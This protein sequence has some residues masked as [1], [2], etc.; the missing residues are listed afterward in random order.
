MNGQTFLLRNLRIITPQRTLE[1]ASLFI[2]KEVIANIYE[3][4]SD[5]PKEV[6][7]VFDLDGLTLYPGFIDIHIHGAVGVDTME[8]DA[9]DLHKVAKFLSTNGV[10]S[11]LPTLVP[12]SDENYVRVADAVSQLM[13]EEKEKESV[14]R[15]L[16]LHYE[17]PFIN[18]HQCGALRPPFFKT[19]RNIADIAPLAK[20]KS[21][22]AIHFTTLAPEIEGG[23]DLIKELV[24]ENWIVSIGHTRSTIDLLEQAFEAGAKHITHFMNAMSPLH[25]RVPGVIGWGL[26]KDDV[27]CDMIADGVHTDPLMLRLALRCKTADRLAL[28]SDAVAP[29]GLGDGEYEIWGEKICVRYGKTE[30]ER[31]SIAGSVIT[32]LDAVRFMLNLGI[33]EKDV[34][35]MASLNPARTLKI[36]KDYGSIEIGKRADVAAV[37]REGNACLTIIGGRVA[38][39]NF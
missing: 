33:D 21:E 28:I 2:E 29:T 8:A 30:N 25:H 24:K 16:G 11:W 23:V 7:K 13:S 19:F 32:M 1:G 34:A 37:D 18:P 6:S 15:A 35:K 20:I 4:D 10:T 36:D 5:V 9:D 39:A 27:I 26:L 22:R 17:G 14:S 12:A 31:G 3:N 38:Y